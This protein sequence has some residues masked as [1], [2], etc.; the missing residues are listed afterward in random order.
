MHGWFAFYVL[1]EIWKIYASFHLKFL[2]QQVRVWSSPSS[3]SQ[4]TTK[5]IKYIN[6][7]QTVGVVCP[8]FPSFIFLAFITCYIPVIFIAIKSLLWQR[9]YIY[10][11]LNILIFWFYIDVVVAYIHVHS[12]TLSSCCY[13]HLLQA[14]RRRGRTPTPGKYLGLKTIRGVFHYSFLWLHLWLSTL[15]FFQIF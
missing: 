15:F 7:H 14:R 1:Y 9:V 12:N 6:K 3:N 2:W 4:I 11:G 13:L 5:Q 8:A 10:F